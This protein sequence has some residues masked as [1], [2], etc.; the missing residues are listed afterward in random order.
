MVL[1]VWV[2]PFKPD[3]FGLELKLLL[4]LLVVGLAVVHPGI[5]VLVSVETKDD[6]VRVLWLRTY[7]NLRRV[8]HW[9]LIFRV[10]ASMLVVVSHDSV[11]V[12]NLRILVKVV[13]EPVTLDVEEAVAISFIAIELRRKALNLIVRVGN[14]LLNLFVGLAVNE[15]WELYTV[16]LAILDFED[17]FVLHEESEVVLNGEVLADYGSAKWTGAIWL[18]LRH[19]G[20]KLFD[21][22]LVLRAAFFFA[23]TY[24]LALLEFLTVWHNVS[25]LSE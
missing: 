23:I 20:N 9:L 21:G 6:N 24:V 11:R 16:T 4:P 13:P 2:V 19:S 3:L 14:D 5:F 18:K 8:D 1:F 12:S 17:R 10:G 15:D 22:S 7:H 25:H